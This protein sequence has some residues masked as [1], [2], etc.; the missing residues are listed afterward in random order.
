MLTISLEE[1]KFY[2]GHG[3]Y[4][5]EAA[6]KNTFLV[7]V[8]VTIDAPEKID[9]L[10]QTVDYEKLYEIIDRQMKTD[11][12]FLETLALA[13]LRQIK[14]NFTQAKR[15]E[16]KISKLHPPMGGEIGRSGIKLIKT[17]K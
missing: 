12:P 1:V 7:D 6:I 17:F 14:E 2:G 13:C 15:I 11:V 8:S 16:I 3:I 5:E 9:R 4:P 10:S